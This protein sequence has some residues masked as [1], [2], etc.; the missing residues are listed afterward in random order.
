MDSFLPTRMEKLNRLVTDGATLGAVCFNICAEL[1]GPQSW[2][3]PDHATI[4]AQL[5]RKYISSREARGHS[6]KIYLIEG[7][8]GS[9]SEN[10]QGRMG[11]QSVG[12]GL[13]H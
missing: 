5:Q 12:P 13:I 2:I 7:G 11:V 3:P 1:F 4:I 6:Q 8:Q 10:G 9:L